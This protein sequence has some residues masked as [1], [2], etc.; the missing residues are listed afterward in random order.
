M[1]VSKKYDM[2]APMPIVGAM[3]NEH[4]PKLEFHPWPRSFRRQAPSLALEFAAKLSGPTLLSTDRT[5]K[6]S[7]SYS[8]KLD[9]S[10]I[11]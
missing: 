10:Q 8:G 4:G 11:E 7:S 3:F 6:V 1:K 5:L 9:C 2:E